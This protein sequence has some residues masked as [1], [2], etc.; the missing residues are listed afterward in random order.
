MNS[1][2]IALKRKPKVS[3]LHYACPP[4][5]GG[6]EITIN[7]HARI[8]LE[9]GYQVGI[10]TG[11]GEPFLPNAKF[12]LIPE[13]NT[14]N[15]S[16]QKMGEELA[17]GKVGRNFEILRDRI[18]DKLQP[19]L[20]EY[21]VC[22]VHNAMSLH[23][24]LA[25]T[26]ALKILNDNQATNFIAWNHDF[27]WHDNLYIPDLHEGYPWELL[28][29]PW[30]GVKYVVVSE[31]RKGRL[32]KLLNINENDI[33]VVTPG[34]DVFDFLQLQPLTRK[35]IKK[36][37][38][39]NSYPLML[40]PARIIFRKNIQYALEATAILKKRFPTGWFSSHGSTWPT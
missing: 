21:E 35:L 24:N 6:V 4:V 2:N 32:A 40:L 26:A 39:L 14:R 8:L 5:V 27:A 29:V 7:H 31:H 34:V 3:I 28:R 25:L 20:E 38:L 9:L 12:Y 37:E 11:R 30:N 16:V 18:V 22:I 13:L 19:I 17:A 23:L 33:E 15:E 36:L 1:T 10:V